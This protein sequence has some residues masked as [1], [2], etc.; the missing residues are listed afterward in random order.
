MVRIRVTREGLYNGNILTKIA[1]QLGMC[2]RLWY[3]TKLQ[4]I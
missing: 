2:V 4:S 1:I 3:P